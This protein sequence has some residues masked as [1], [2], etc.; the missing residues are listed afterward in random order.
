M[1]NLSISRQ[2]L[3]GTQ[4]MN[5]ITAQRSESKIHVVHAIPGRVRLR[6]TDSKLTSALDEAAQH[7]R[8]RLDG[9]CEVQ[10]NPTTNSL[11][12]TFDESRLSLSQTLEIL[13]THA[14]I[15]ET[16][17]QIQPSSEKLESFLQEPINLPAQ[18][19]QV[20]KS[21]LPIA[22]GF[23]VTGVLGIEGL[24]ALPIY[25]VASSTT[26]QVLKR[27]ESEMSASDRELIS[28]N[29]STQGNG[30]EATVAEPNQS[31][32]QSPEVDYQI[33]HEIRGRIRFKVPRLATDPDYVQRLTVLSKTDAKVTE[34][35]L[36]T[37]ARS[38]AFSYDADLMGTQKMRSHLIDLI[39]SASQPNIF[40]DLKAASLQEEPEPEP[41]FWSGLTL[42]ALTTTLALLGGPLGLPIPPLIIGSTIAV[43]TLPVAQRALESILNEKKLNID[44]LDLMAIS[45]MTLQGHF[46]S[47]AIMLLLIEI[48]E[49]IREQTAKSS[50]QQT[51]DL[52]ASLEQLV[53]VEC[54]GEKQQIS[55]H[56]VRPGDVVIVYPGSQI[57]VDGRIIRGKALIDEQKLTGE[58]MPVM[59]KKGQS[60]YTST[61][62][63]EGQ[64]YILAE[65]VG[66]DTRAGQIIKVMQ[67]APVHDTR[68]ENYAATVANQAVVPTL[69][70]SGLVLA[71]TGNLARAAS[72]LTLDLA[73]GIRVSVPT[74]VLAALTA[75]ARKGILI[76]SG[77]ALEKL[78]EVD[79]VVF[80][81]TGTLTQ[82]EPAIVWVE[83]VSESTS[84]L[85]VIELAAAAEQRLTHPVAVAIVRYAQ[86]QGA[87]ILPRGKWDYIIGLGVRAE[88][89]GESILVGSDRFL[90]QEGISLEVLEKKQI[91]HFTSASNS[92][93]YVASN[94]ELLGAMAYRDPLRAESPDV[95]KALKAEGMDIHL[96]T[97]DQERTAFAV[98]KELG[99][100]PE[101]TH[102][103]A[104]PE[105]KVAVVK[106]LK[107]KGKIVAFAGDGINDSPAL[108]H[109][110]VSISFGNGS[111]VARETADVVL[112]ENNLN[113]LPEA[114]A[115][116]RQAIE[117][118]HQNTG[119][120]A[121]PNLG[122]LMLAVAVGIDPLA[123]TLVNN[124]TT[125]IAGLNGLRPLLQ[126]NEFLPP[127]STQ[128]ATDSPEINNVVEFTAPQPSSD[129]KPYFPQPK[130][131]IAENS[132]AVKSECSNG[133]GV[134]HS[135]NT[136][137]FHKPNPL[138]LVAIKEIEQEI[139]QQPTSEVQSN[140]QQR[141]EAIADNSKSQMSASSQK[142][143]NGQHKQGVNQ[144]QKNVTE[145]LTG[146]ALANR[147][148][149]ST[150]TISRRKTKPDFSKWTR[151]KD[152]SGI[153]WRYSKSS[154]LFCAV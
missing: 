13:Q 41:N 36:N 43:A 104:F 26:R 150:T 92:V 107:D 139:E 121:I 94:G 122:A 95:I 22:A 102:A 103:E 109:A 9:M 8:Q 37:D 1:K 67:E 80:D 100:T 15:A 78:A 112:M 82:G 24:V 50:Q 54:N 113:G 31:V 143:G 111:E 151:S 40:L 10:T 35:R 14:G 108:A 132:L 57:P 5:E 64:L 62:V 120:V 145:R 81:K 77:R 27:L 70:V 33:V 136:N 137:G 11:V 128:P 7:L 138:T 87:R 131:A 49:A 89:D 53:W 61:L 34:V 142:N 93:I 56:E 17:R 90:I 12:V 23:L 52:L 30:K 153:A 124:G 98:A 147:L 71:F 85:R 2:E 83:T 28:Q 140:S 47:P 29:T 149:V 154:K 75:A 88:I 51:L 39:Q 144:V 99:I 119:I 105:Q 96:L 125:V 72:I 135:V 123:A 117:L 20:A 86:K 148:N 60:V 32:A 4:K 21:V 65:K 91:P 68:I 19:I 115:I 114:I 130:I 106:D 55:I 44:F 48:G 146:T 73:T 66:T 3:N 134:K 141:K 97:G 79:A 63:R 38:I 25:M 59:R 84:K 152:P 74:T 133:N 76:R 69:L 45:I 16:P 18:G 118:I 116:A 6:T 126:D 127:S 42:P 101:N 129:V 46:I 110:E 58:A